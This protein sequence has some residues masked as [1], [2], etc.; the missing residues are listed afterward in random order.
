[1]NSFNKTEAAV[2]SCRLC[3]LRAFS[4]ISLIDMSTL[5]TAFFLQFILSIL[6]Q[7]QHKHLI[8]GF[9]E[10]CESLLSWYFF[11]KKI[12]RSTWTEFRHD[13]VTVTIH[14]TME[15]CLGC[16]R[17]CLHTLGYILQAFPLSYMSTFS[18]L[19]FLIILLFTLLSFCLYSTWPG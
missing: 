10:Q 11:F 2:F 15:N 5:F 1:M 19:L 13:F 9:A 7:K 4:F 18:H 14:P 6:S 3:F 12:R 16:H 17:C 8:T